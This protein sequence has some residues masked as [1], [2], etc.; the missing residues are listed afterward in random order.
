MSERT[1]KDI[2]DN[3]PWI[4]IPLGRD[5]AKKIYFWIKRLP[6]T[7][8]ADEA[9]AKEC[10]D[11]ISK[12]FNDLNVRYNTEKYGSVKMEN[13]RLFSGGDGIAIPETCFIDPN[14]ELKRIANPLRP[15]T[16]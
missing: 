1:W 6:S 7:K 15:L 9:L 5:D 8:E 13:L 12:A 11:A 14:D 2:N 3:T 10:E 16:T 4:F